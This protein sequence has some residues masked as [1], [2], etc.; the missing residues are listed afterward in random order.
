MFTKLIASFET[1][2]Q[3][4]CQVHLFRCKTTRVPSQNLPRNPNNHSN[5]SLWN[6][7]LAQLK[8]P[9]KKP[10]SDKYLSYKYFFLAKPKEA[11]IYAKIEMN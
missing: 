8:I 1:N 6:F 9:M 4:K 7:P 3:T 10:T 5:P 2:T 11:L